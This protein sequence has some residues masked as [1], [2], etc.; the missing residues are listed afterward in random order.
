MT[1]PSP[2]DSF[3]GVWPELLNALDAASLL[4]LARFVDAAYD[5]DDD[6]KPPRED[7]FNAFRTP[8]EDVRVVILGEDPYPKP[9]HA[10]GLAFSVRRDVQRIPG[11]LKQIYDELEDDP[12]V[13]FVRP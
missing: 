7:L 5:E 1:Y 2:R 6:V 4:D 8:F 13:C 11:A 3:P 12:E 10:M 9:D